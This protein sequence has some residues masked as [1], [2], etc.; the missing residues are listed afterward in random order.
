MKYTGRVLITSIVF[1]VSILCHLILHSLNLSQ[2]ILTMFYSLF[3]WW[4]GKQYD[5]SRYLFNKLQHKKEEIQSLFDNNN[6]MFWTVEIV[7][8]KIKVSKGVK[9]LWGYTEAEFEKHYEFWIEASHPDDKEKAC[10]YFS[11]LLSGQPSSAEWR[12]VRK[13][14]EVRWIKS[15]GNPIFL[16]GKIV[17]MNGV[18]YDITEQKLSEEKIE[19]LA[20]HDSL[21]GLVNRAMLKNHLDK[22]VARCKRNHQKLAVMFLD[23]DRFKWINDTMG[24]NIGDELIIQVSQRLVKSVREEDVVARQGGDEFIILLEGITKL[25]VMNISERIL[26]AFTT[27]FTLNGEEIFASPSV[28]IS[29]Y[30]DNGRDVETLIKHADKAMYLAKKRGKNNYQ[31]YVHEDEQV[32]DQKNKIEQALKRALINNEFQLYYQPKVI[33]K[34]QEIYGVEAL[35]RWQHP[36]L[37]IISPAEFIPIAEE[38]GM[39][40][41][42]GRWVLQE[43]C[44]QLKHWHQSGLWLKMAVNVSAL[45]FQDPQ[46]LQTVKE[47]LDKCQITPK[48]IGFEITES[49]MQN[50]KESTCMINQLK[51]LG[52]RISIDDFGTGY[53]SLSVL[54]N[55]PI[56]LIKID[57]SF[58]DDI[59]TNGTAASLVKTII[60]MGKNLHFELIAEGIEN[61]QQVEFLIQ[62][63]CLYG[64]GYYFSPPLSSVE[65]EAFIKQ[66][67]NKN[68]SLGDKN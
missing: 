35:L 15:F 2:F 59:L 58:I 6:I 28:G 23:L 12:I 51:K 4:L 50:I 13:D 30:P 19:Y 65:V 8:K 7:K 18:A 40:V 53:S 14:G 44:K 52:I 20:Y 43:A 27:P 38:T 68:H 49:V 10:F 56:D 63:G 39:I 24:H 9:E 41:P 60:E 47:S 42:I 36:E 48:Y 34:T 46:F 32:Q 61:Q 11:E 3:A 57:K 25:G 21:T 45:Q 22:A 67:L 16:N 33:L 17:K 66:G 31:F 54:S 26:Y 37:G 55:L 1:I 29:L 64:Q 5:K 62:N